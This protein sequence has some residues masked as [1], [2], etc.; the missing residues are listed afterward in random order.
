MGLL[1]L[2]SR[3]QHMV[4]S[5]RQKHLCKDVIDGEEIYK[6]K[7][8]LFLNGIYKCNQYTLFKPPTPSVYGFETSVL[9][10]LMF[11]CSGFVHHIELI[12]VVILGA[13]LVKMLSYQYRISQCAD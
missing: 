7:I 2:W 8:K 13:E 10:N 1:E 6:W 12:L 9:L 4:F 5:Y 3:I 11:V